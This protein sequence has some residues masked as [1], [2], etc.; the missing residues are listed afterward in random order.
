[1]FD[2]WRCR[3]LLILFIFVVLGYIM[4]IYSYG[5]FFEDVFSLNLIMFI[6]FILDKLVIFFIGL[7]VK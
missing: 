3:I 6:R 4:D 2:L 7:K 5:Y 1:M